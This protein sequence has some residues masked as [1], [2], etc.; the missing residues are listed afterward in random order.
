M[1]PVPQELSEEEA[2]YILGAQAN[3]WTEY[4]TTPEQVEYM[5]LPRM[6]ALDEVVWT[7]AEEKNWENFEERLEKLV[8][9][10]DQLGY[11]Y[12]THLFEEE[13]TKD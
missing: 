3:V 5:V 11:N 7:P 6:S 4:I 12:A 8:K 13:Q 2:K 1:E 9:R 10:F